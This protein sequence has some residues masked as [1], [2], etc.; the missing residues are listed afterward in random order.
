MQ[1]L[2]EIR[3]KVLNWFGNS[4][5]DYTNQWLCYGFDAICHDLKIDRE[6]VR[7][8]CRHLA[9]LGYV[10]YRRGLWTGEGTPAGSGYNLTIVGHKYLTQRRGGEQ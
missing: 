4:H 8:M 7:F 5:Q 6:T 1:S 2:D 3:L 10:E 9:S